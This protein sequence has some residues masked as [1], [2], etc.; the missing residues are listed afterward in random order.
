MYIYIYIYI[1]YLEHFW[2]PKKTI[3]RKLLINSG[4]KWQ[5]WLS[6]ELQTATS[7]NPDG[8]FQDAATTAAII[9][10]SLGSTSLQNLCS[11]WMTLKRGDCLNLF[12]LINQAANRKASTR[13]SLAVIWSQR[14]CAESKMFLARVSCWALLSAVITSNFS[15]RPARVLNHQNHLKRDSI[16]PFPAKHQL[17][18]NQNVDHGWL[19]SVLWLV[20]QLSKRVW[21]CDRFPCL[22]ALKLTHTQAPAL[23]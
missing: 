16:P 7:F 22:P 18:S 20:C 19:S 23:Q 10:V 14:R 4:D 1:L 9:A 13:I 17:K 11:T 21:S 12:E 2:P 15:M 8:R 3:M 5:Y 6:F